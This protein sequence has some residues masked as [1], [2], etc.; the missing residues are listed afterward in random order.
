MIPLRD[1]HPISNIEQV[2]QRWLEGRTVSKG[3]ER[4]GESHSRWFSVYIFLLPFSLHCGF[5][6]LIS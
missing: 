2:S 3:A 6:S 1:S 5:G 4:K